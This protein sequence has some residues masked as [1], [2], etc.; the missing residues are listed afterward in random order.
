MSTLL[1]SPHETDLIGAERILLEANNLDRQKVARSVEALVGTGDFADL[2]FESAQSEHW[3]LDEGRVTSGNFSAV[4]GVGA[5]SVDGDRTAFAHSGLISP[6]GLDVTLDAVASM[7]RQGDDAARSGGL[8][9][10]GHASARRLFVPDN[11]IEATEAPEKIA[12]LRDIDRRARAVD[13][14]VVRVSASLSASYKV[15]LVADS[16]G[17]MAADMRPELQI[18][19]AVHVERNGRRSAG[20]DSLGGRYRIGDIPEGAIDQLVRR[21]VHRA[22]VGLDARPAPAGVMPVVLG[23]GFPGVLLHEAVGHGLEGDAHRKR[24]SVFVDRMLQRVAAPGVTVVDD[25][26]IPGRVGSL[27]VDDEGTETQRNVLIEDGRLVGLMQDRMNAGL[28]NARRT[29]N[30]RRQSYRH[31]PMPRM[32]NTYLEAGPHD[33]SDILA[34]VKNGIYAVAFAGGQVDIT[35]GQFNFSANEA[36]LI[37]DGKVTAPL[38]G[39]TL[40]GLGHEALNHISMVG[41]DLMIENGVCGKEGQS[42]NVGVGQPTIRIDELVVGGTS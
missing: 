25:G 4:Q 19:V 15:S 28:M 16:D 14:A 38:L 41:N 26:T 1:A 33:P 30:A 40:I 8:A 27:H 32:T 3:S 31:L 23:P 24:S 2:Y 6:D 36:Y 13:P 21:A 12:L 18:G 42:V 34:S 9:L 5:R 7:R 29:G 22:M 39:A 37:E 35:S 20:N 10:N 11:P 17:A